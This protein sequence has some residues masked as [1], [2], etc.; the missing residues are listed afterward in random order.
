MAL[1]ADLDLPAFPTAAPPAATGTIWIMADDPPP[2]AQAWPASAPIPDGWHEV[3]YHEAQRALAPPVVSISFAGL[4]ALPTVQ[5]EAAAL[6]TAG[7]SPG[8]VAARSLSRTSREPRP[9][10]VSR[11]ARRPRPPRPPRPPR[12]PRARRP[13]RPRRKPRPRRPPRARRPRNY[14]TREKPG[15]CKGPGCTCWTPAGCAPPDY[16]GVF[17]DFTKTDCYRGPCYSYEAC[18]SDQCQVHALCAINQILQFWVGQYRAVVAYVE[19]VVAPVLEAAR[20]ALQPLPAIGLP[21]AELSDAIPV[22]PPGSFGCGEQGWIWQRT[23][24]G[25]RCGPPGTFGPPC[26]EAELIAAGILPA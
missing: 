21:P 13:P 4:A 16:V 7:P 10:R 18:V 19:P 12:A 24:I 5:S 22:A 3:P 23:T 17:G 2:R 6:S 20:A 8:V 14:K 9:P 15:I 25:C 26:T 1:V 11:P